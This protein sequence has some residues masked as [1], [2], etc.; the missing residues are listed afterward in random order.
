MIIL[1]IGIFSRL[2]PVPYLLDAGPR[3]KKEKGDGLVFD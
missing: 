1:N 3:K 2:I